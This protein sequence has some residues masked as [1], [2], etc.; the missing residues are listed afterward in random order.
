MEASVV[1]RGWS[2]RAYRAT[3]GRSAALEVGVLYLKRGFWFEIGW[4]ESDYGFTM[5]TFKS[6]LGDFGAASTWGL[7]DT[8]RIV[9]CTVS[10]SFMCGISPSHV[11]RTCRFGWQL[12][13][14]A[15]M[16]DMVDHEGYARRRGL[17]GYF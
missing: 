17:F 5:R 6:W 13:C 9:N 7:W 2:G 15:D 1:A 8:F 4:L 10:L 16:T 14:T 3:Y 11:H 12:T